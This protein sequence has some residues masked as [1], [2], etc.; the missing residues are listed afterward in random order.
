MIA[1]L[2]GKY[3]FF[4]VLPTF[5]KVSDNEFLISAKRRIHHK[6]ELSLVIYMTEKFQD[7]DIL[8]VKSYKSNVIPETMAL[9]PKFSLRITE[10][11]PNQK[12]VSTLDL[13]GLRTI[14]EDMQKN[15]LLWKSFL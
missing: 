4:Y 9:L 8:G 6:I 2:G 3:L 5:V 11:L 12:L 7:C 1:R 10:M 13:G 15:I 14:T